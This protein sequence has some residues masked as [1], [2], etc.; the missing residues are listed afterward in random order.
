MPFLETT[1]PALYYPKTAM[2]TWAVAAVVL[3]DKAPTLPHVDYR[4]RARAWASHAFA[5]VPLSQGW[6]GVTAAVA[7]DFADA[8]RPGAGASACAVPGTEGAVAPEA[9]APGAVPLDSNV[10]SPPADCAAAAVACFL[11]II[12]PSFFSSI[13]TQSVRKTPAARLRS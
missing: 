13:K 2:L 5:P 1:E 8:R 12:P 10:P 6:G 4:P 7:L 9:A 3:T 11:R